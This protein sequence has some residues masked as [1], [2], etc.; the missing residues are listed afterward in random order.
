MLEQ[1]TI[2]KKSKQETN[3]KLLWNFS[4]FWENKFSPKLSHCLQITSVCRWKRPVYGQ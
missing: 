4:N 3:A 1:E 2:I